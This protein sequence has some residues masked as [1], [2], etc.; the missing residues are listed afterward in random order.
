MFKPKEFIFHKFYIT[1]N[2]FN[3]FKLNIYKLYIIYKFKVYE[4]KL[5]AKP[6][7]VKASPTLS[8]LDFRLRERWLASSESSWYVYIVGMLRYR[9]LESGVKASHPLIPE[10][11]KKNL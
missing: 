7:I 5:I 3:Y 4:I 6:W 1:K 11:Y 8:S 9:E 10:Y 2:P